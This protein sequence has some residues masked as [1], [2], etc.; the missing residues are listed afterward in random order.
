MKSLIQITRAECVQFDQSHLGRA[1]MWIKAATP[2]ITIL[3][4][5][6][7]TA[8]A[9]RCW[10][11]TEWDRLLKYYDAAT[12]V[13]EETIRLTSRGNAAWTVID[14]ADQRYSSVTIARTELA[15]A[16]GSTPGRRRLPRGISRSS[17]QP[18]SSR[19]RA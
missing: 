16:S 2:F 8:R 4:L 10:R 19:T 18:P 11:I 17:L 7:K 13:Q 5:E 1:L 14:A 6:W 9:I 12:H 15:C 3:A